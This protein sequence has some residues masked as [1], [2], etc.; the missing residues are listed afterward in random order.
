MSSNTARI[1]A[2]SYHNGRVVNPGYGSS[3]SID[4]LFILEK[5]AATSGESDDKVEYTRGGLGRYVKNACPQSGEYGQT[6]G[7]RGR[8]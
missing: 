7:P 6:C 8:S 2:V 3:D 5:S 4:D 1:Q